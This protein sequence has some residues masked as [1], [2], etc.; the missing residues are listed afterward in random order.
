M[1]PTP[2][3]REELLDIVAIAARQDWRAAVWLLEHEYPAK[4][5]STSARDETVRSDGSGLT[6]ERIVTV[7]AAVCGIRRGQILSDDRL[8]SASRARHVAMYLAKEMTTSSYTEIGNAF[9]RDHTT[10][11]SAHEKITILV[12]TEEPKMCALVSQARDMLLATG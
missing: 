6:I 4:R 5:P 7:S 3:T 10:V 9:G 1:A 8:K 2:M 11:M 12:E